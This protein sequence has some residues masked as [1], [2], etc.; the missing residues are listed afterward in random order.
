MRRILK[1]T[2]LLLPGLILA[3]TT[4]LP[5][6]ASG[7]DLLPSRD[8]LIK[9]YE[10]DNGVR[11][12]LFPDPVAD[13]FTVNV[14]VLAGSR[15]E[16]SGEAG[17]AHLLSHMLFKGT[18]T[19]PDIP[20]ALRDHGAV[21]PI[22]AN[23]NTTFDRTLFFETMPANDENLEFAIRLEADRL[24]NGNIKR[25]DLGSV[26]AVVRNQVEINENDLLTFFRQRMMAAAFQRHSYGKAVL[27]NQ[28]D[29]ERISVD[30][31]RA[32]YRKHYRPDNVVVVIAGK[33]DA[34]KA[35]EY[36]SKYF[37]VLKRPAEKLESRSAEE[38]PQD[39]ERNIVVRRAGSESAVCAMYHVPAGRHE[40][41]PA[42]QVLLQ[43][44]AASPNGRL[45]ESLVTSKKANEISGSAR[46]FH[47]PGIFEIY[48]FG[49]AKKSIDQ[50]RDTMLE[51]V[52]GIQST[53]VTAE[54]V[55][56]AKQTIAIGFDELCANSNQM[57]TELSDYACQGGWRLFF[58][59]RDRVAKVTP[60]DVMRVAGRYLRRSNRTVGVYLPTERAQSVAI[61]AAKSAAEVLRGYEGVGTRP[62]GESLARIS[63][64]L[65]KRVRRSELSG[66]VKVALFPKKTANDTVTALLTLRFGNERSLKG[67]DA[68]A[69]FLGAL[70]LRG[71]TKRHSYQQLGEECDKLN[72][73]VF[74]N[75]GL[76]S[77]SCTI[78]SKKE[79]FPRVLRLVREILR[80]PAFAQS[81]L[82]AKKRE[83]KQSL[84][85][86]R[87]NPQA[88]A[89]SAVRRKLA[90]FPK[91]DPRYV[92]TLDEAIAQV[93]AVTADQVRKLYTEQL[94]GQTGEFVAVGAFNEP[95]TLELLQQ[96]LADWKT[97][98]PYERIVQRA[99]TD[100]AGG[101]WRIDVPDKDA[102]Y[103][104]S[105]LLQMKDDHPDY[106]P[107]QVASFVL[108][109]SSFA[110][111]L[112]N[113]VRQNEGL[114]YAVE[115]NFTA[116]DEDAYA[117]FA[118]EATCNP[119]NIDKLDRAISEEL[120]RLVTDGISEKELAETKK[121]LL[122]QRLLSLSDDA[123]LVSLLSYSLRS[124]NSLDDF[125]IRGKRIAKLTVAQVNEAIRKH[126]SPNRLVI[127]RA[128]DFKKASERRN[129]A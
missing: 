69:Q 101:R 96:A 117:Q 105:H 47:D 65:E 56:R 116:D 84:E 15:H 94:G 34:Q 93:D 115:C 20:K 123:Q 103:F 114:S 102:Y 30:Q 52:E 8:D 48:A 25:E 88:L 119:E 59:Q 26:I 40:D 109:G 76:G 18:P 78:V 63:D 68:A 127:I 57:A 38:P 70:M 92:P 10:I 1:S 106:Y 39:G 42:I 85:S 53:P 99:P 31:L 6:A 91:D 58:L 97:E 60:A 125:G 82:N 2:R 45:Y 50:V 104:A 44:L 110:S 9:G 113:R 64:S 49:D 112:G 128:G 67:Y 36:M 72:A 54:E 24:V 21:M 35:L 51:V 108:G 90:P 122:E 11:F 27:G 89:R 71:G 77:L 5:A 75:S 55:E 81:E 3:A 129:G 23:A 66:G 124:G 107:L 22:T 14:V 120:N 13:K 61:P 87:T 74:L 17:M 43:I 37:G 83:L 126:I 33:F 29:I 118:V 86:A 80:E 79:T 12:L 98:I 121:L 4:F 32:F 95:S 100:V 28:S 16:G 73:S 41:F 111:R 19:H 7:Q 62:S 46:P